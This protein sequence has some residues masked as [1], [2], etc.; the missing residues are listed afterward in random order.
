VEVG[1]GGFYLLEK[2]ISPHKLFLSFNLSIMDQ[3]AVLLS[4]SSPFWTLGYDPGR[5]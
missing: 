1:G 4:S 3:R 5:F 2:L